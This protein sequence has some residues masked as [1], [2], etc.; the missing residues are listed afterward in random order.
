[1][2]GSTAGTLSGG[3][4]GGWPSSRVIT[5]APRITGD[6]FVPLAV[7]FWIAACVRRPPSGLPGG[8]GTLRTAWPESGSKE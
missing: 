3:F 6:V 8:T 4:G 5:Q 2:S 7:T 1:M